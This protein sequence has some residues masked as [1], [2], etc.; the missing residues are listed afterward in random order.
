MRAERRALVQNDWG[1]SQGDAKELN[2]GK[3]EP[4][5][6]QEAEREETSWNT[7][8]KRVQSGK[9]VPMLWSQ[10]GSQR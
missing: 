5:K 7:R 2:T 1:Q 9:G 10:K 4:L 3:R 8:D 6:A